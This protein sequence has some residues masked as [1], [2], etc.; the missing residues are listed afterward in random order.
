MHAVLVVSY[1]L[2]I[3]FLTMVVTR[4]VTINFF[5]LLLMVVA[6]AVT[7]AVVGFRGGFIKQKLE[8]VYLYDVRVALFTKMVHQP[9]GRILTQQVGNSVAQL[10][11]QLELLR[12]NYL[13]AMLEMMSLA[14]QFGLAFGYALFLNGGLAITI[15][16]L[17]IPAVLVPILAKNILAKA[18][19]PVIT[20]M[21]HYTATMTNWVQGLTTIKNFG[22]EST[23]TRLH[24]QEAQALTAAEQHDILI[25]KIIAG[26]SA[27]SG[28]AVYLGTWLI[29]TYLVLH[30]QLG[31]PQL[32]AFAQLSVSISFPVEALTDMLTELLGGR[33]LFARYQKQLTADMPLA[34]L[35]TAP[36]APAQ[37]FLAFDHVSVAAADKEILHDINLHFQ[38]KDR[39]VVVGESGAGKS[40]L[41]NTIFGYQ[42]QVSGRV[43]VAGVPVSSSTAQFVTDAIGFQSQKTFIF[44]AS[45]RDNLT[46]FDDQVSEAAIMHVLAAVHLDTW[47][48]N[49]PAGLATLIGTSGNELSGGERQRLALARNLL[50]PKHFLVLDELTSGLDQQHAKMVEQ[51]LFS[52][53]MGF[54]LITHQF[55]AELLQQADY[56]VQI[57]QHQ[58][59]VLSPAA[60]QAL[61]S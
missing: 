35:I 16:L 23:F 54:M 9:V 14:L 19:T 39:V 30:R 50:K 51:V 56:V 10:T 55:D 44:D 41:V 15:L 12:T 53:P 29:G 27:L 2:V 8:T 22:R 17:E 3:Q 28:D 46:L 5:V 45:V 21:A 34:K 59:K 11:N 52:L 25:R 42:S 31:V 13:S 47:V 32:M 43:F 49:Q 33:Q 40:T 4:S 60:I 24:E 38:A 18:K 1:A 36:T 58:A 20:Q 6:F 37:S 57:K 7:M 26:L 48:V 61:L